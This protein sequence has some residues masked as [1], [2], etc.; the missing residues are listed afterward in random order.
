MSSSSYS[1]SQ[2]SLVYSKSSRSFDHDLICIPFAV[3]QAVAV[4][5]AS[6]TIGYAFGTRTS[7]TSPAKGSET[8][9]EPAV[10]NKPPAEAPVEEEEEESEEESED[11]GDGDLSAVK[12]GMFDQCKLVRH[13]VAAF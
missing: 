4:V 13:C 9:A 12:P 3:V 7:Q 2:S 10:S 1:T 11:E 5:A 8:K 6:L